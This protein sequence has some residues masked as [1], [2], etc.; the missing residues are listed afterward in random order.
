MA[1]SEVLHLATSGFA[2]IYLTLPAGAFLN[3]WERGKQL[4]G[5]ERGITPEL[6]YVLG[7]PNLAVRL[8]LKD[9]R[10]LI[11]RVYPSAG[12]K[13]IVANSVFSTPYV[14]ASAPTVVQGDVI[15]FLTHMRARRSVYRKDPV[16]AEMLIVDELRKLTMGQ[17]VSIEA[18]VG[19]ADYVVSG[20]LAVE[21]LPLFLEWLVAFNKITINPNVA[22][23][24]V[25]KRTLTLIGYPWTTKSQAAPI[26]PALAAPTKAILFIRVQRG[27]LLEASKALQRMFNEEPSNDIEVSFVDGK[28]D[29]VAICRTPQSD[30]LQRHRDLVMEAERYSIERIETHL[31]FPG[32]SEE[33]M[34]PFSLSPSWTPPNDDCDCTL[35]PDIIKVL[36]DSGRL[37]VLPR[38][39]ATAVKNI[40]FLSSSTCEEKASCCDARPGVMACWNSLNALLHDIEQLQMV[41]HGPSATANDRRAKEKEVARLIRRIDLWVV[42][43][44]RVLRQR[45]VGSFEEFLGQSDR[46]LS[47]GGGVQKGLL[48]SDLLMNDFYSKV[49]GKRSKFRFAS[50]YDSV[51]RITSVVKTGIVRIPVT[52]AFYIPGALPDLW[53]EV[54]G[55]DFFRALPQTKFSP[56][57]SS[58]AYRVLADHYGD[59]VSLV[60]GFE[61]NFRQ[62][63]TALT[64]AF[65]ESVRSNEPEE[66]KE[67]KF[68]ELLAR[69]VAASEML[70]K[71]RRHDTSALPNRKLFL[72]SS[73]G[74]MEQFA[75][76]Y[77]GSFTP[78]RQKDSDRGERTLRPLV[79][80]GENLGVLHE[81][82]QML[83]KENPLTNDPYD[84]VIRDL[85][86][87]EPAPLT[88]FEV[89]TDLNAEFRKLL[90]AIEKTRRQPG[91]RAEN[92]HAPMAALARSAAIEYYRRMAPE[93]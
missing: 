6:L 80:A 76:A 59:F 22:D 53:H 29:I 18:G 61:L 89:D 57:V 23:G 19:W 87:D 28:L 8:P 88:R 31:M 37:E 44:D 4:A 79:L 71:V 91:L 68:T 34:Q 30:F 90:W 62:F 40:A 55:F 54:G 27:R 47:Y 50:V 20:R 1:Q 48:V 25:F 16:R 39:T 45:T 17:D 36:L 7:Q 42:I 21:K 5:I 15:R 60:F 75:S 13:A 72:L 3:E 83:L 84:T 86:V 2:T 49:T 66:S 92:A 26:I 74:K 58:S 65:K 70:A 67:G 52:R 35:F 64:H 82:I 38:G 41:I 46:S 81:R 24:Y 93:V 12:S 77:L 10:H 63:A 56:E 33:E 73:F 11:E 69:L 32:S 85:K 14:M 78:A 43:T 51:D 9:F